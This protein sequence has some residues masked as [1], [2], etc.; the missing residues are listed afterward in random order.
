MP[1]RSEI[2]PCSEDRLASDGDSGGKPSEQKGRGQSPLGR[3]L[4]RV[5]SSEA[6]SSG[7]IMRCRVLAAACRLRG[8]EVHVLSWCSNPVLRQKLQ[9]NADFCQ[10][11]ETE[12]DSV[13][14]APVTAYAH[15]RSIDIV[16]LDGYHF[17]QEFHSALQDKMIATLVI[18]DNN[19]LDE[20]RCDISVNHNI[21]AENI[22][23]KTIS[24]TKRLFGP[25]YYLLNERFR[26]APRHEKIENKPV[27]AIFATMGGSTY[28]NITYKML[29]GLA[30]HM[31]A[32]MELRL[33]LGPLYK[34]KETLLPLIETTKGRV[35]LIDFTDDIPS[36]MAWAGL[37]LTSGGVTA[38][39]MAY[40]GL[41]MVAT[42]W[43]D[44]QV[45]AV[46]A[47]ADRS[48]ALTCDPSAAGFAE[49]FQRLLSCH[50]TRRIL[51]RNCLD[52]L[53][54]QGPLRIVDAIE[55][56]EPVRKV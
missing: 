20:Y 33:I 53:D 2:L 7:H 36:L 31:T 40:M 3:I 28:K 6:L 22:H 24:T 12:A 9:E 47:L 25:K 11:L 1:K 41:P 5:D 29:S 15:A 23:Y 42:A 21:G 17:G 4:F 55:T 10:F 18:D 35:D 14:T 50:E 44:N 26:S 48:C 32:E 37:G 49:A 46:R 39:E 19:H 45:D 51:S 54:G 13:D 43:V 56:L 30:P 8:W 52:I 27:K 16:V 34:F 38:L